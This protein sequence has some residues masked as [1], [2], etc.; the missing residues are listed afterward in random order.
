MTDYYPPLKNSKK[1]EVSRGR[2]KVSFTVMA[3]FDLM[4]MRKD[5]D[6]MYSELREFHD[7][8]LNELF[9]NIIRE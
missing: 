5:L 9:K 2:S 6:E 1:V 8:K 4:R 7:S 3:T